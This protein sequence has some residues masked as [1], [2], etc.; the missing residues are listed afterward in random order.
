MDKRHCRS[1]PQAAAP[2]VV[3]KVARDKFEPTTQASPKPAT[4]V[5]APSAAAVIPSHKVQETLKSLHENANASHNDSPGTNHAQSVVA[6][7]KIS[8]TIKQFG[9]PELDVARASVPQTV[10][11]RKPT[12]TGALPVPEAAPTTVSSKCPVCD[13]TVYVMEQVEV[14]GSKYHKAYVDVD[15]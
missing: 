14:E 2:V 11:R 3:P 1:A 15:V 6:P 10:V 13:K 7:G 4:S 5:T 8:D 9:L 12:A